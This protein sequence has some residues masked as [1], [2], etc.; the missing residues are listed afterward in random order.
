MIPGIDVSHWDGEI[1]WTAVKDAGVQ[2]AYI[3][4]TEGTK[5]VDPDFTRN[6]EEASQAGLLVG[7]YHYLTTDPFDLQAVNFSQVLPNSGL[8]PA[9]DF[10]LDSLSPSN[11]AA[12]WAIATPTAERVNYLPASMLPQFTNPTG[13]LWI[14]EWDVIAPKYS[15]WPNW[16]FWQHS[17]SGNVRGVGEDVDLDWFNGS[18][19]ELKQFLSKSS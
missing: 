4:A 7:A 12:F 6:W 2:F 10:E 13:L 17:A 14:A 18:L 5:F 9:L 11:I 1:D 15:P 3:K 8:P 16:T 19:D